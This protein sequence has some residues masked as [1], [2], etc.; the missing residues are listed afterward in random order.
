MLAG[1]MLELQA[2]GCHNVNFVT[3]EHV[4]PQVLE[5]LV[6][7]VGDGLRLP[8]VYNTSAYDS[9]ESL[10]LLDGIVDIY[11]PD[12]KLWTSG[13]SK[14]YLMAED[15]PVAALAAIREMHRQVGPLVV[16]EKGLALQGV[17]IRH[18]VMPGLVSETTAILHWVRSELGSD[19][20]VNLMEQY[21]PAGKVG[22]A[23]FSELDRPVTSAE[24]ASARSLALDLGLRLDDRRSGFDKPLFGI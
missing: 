1:M 12:L 24:F 6:L 14:R 10:H 23:R 5:A 15:Y 2:L 8:I 20:Y 9:I 13:A 3:P 22:A 7:A 17:L 11:M 19:T 4:V 18:L 21:R 16:D